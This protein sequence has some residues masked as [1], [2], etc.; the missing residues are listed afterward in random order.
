M[1]EY[2][3]K[4]TG[5]GGCDSHNIEH[6]C[7][8][9]I[10]GKYSEL[11]HIRDELERAKRTINCT[12]DHTIIGLKGERDKLLSDL[13]IAVEA[14]NEYLE[15]QSAIGDESYSAMEFREAL[16]KIKAEP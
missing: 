3:W 11:A 14:I 7:G 4:G 10:T 13:A 1:S 6:P 16:A 2:N 8:P 15:T 12:Q 9:C 5:P